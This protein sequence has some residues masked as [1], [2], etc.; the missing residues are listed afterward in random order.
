MLILKIC[1]WILQ[2][3]VMERVILFLYKDQKIPNAMSGMVHEPSKVAHILWTYLH[4][5]YLILSWPNV[6]ISQTY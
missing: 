5:L 2:I 6:H 4:T 1:H 3:D